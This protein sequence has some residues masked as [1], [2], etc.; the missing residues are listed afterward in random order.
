MSPNVQCFT[1]WTDQFKRALGMSSSLQCGAG[2]GTAEV[3]TLLP[4]LQRGRRGACRS[5]QW[6][7]TAVLT[8]EGQFCPLETGA[9]S[10]DSLSCF[11]FVTIA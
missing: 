7:Q 3:S 4:H 2:F 8:G 1:V 9:M 6:N 10:G 5:S 11:P